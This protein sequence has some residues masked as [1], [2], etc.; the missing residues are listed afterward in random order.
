[1][2]EVCYGT[3]RRP[4]KRELKKRNQNNKSKCKSHGSRRQTSTVRAAHTKSSC[5]QI[6]HT[7]VA[8]GSTNKRSAATSPELS[9][10]GESTACHQSSRNRKVKRTMQNQH[11]SSNSFERASSCQSSSADH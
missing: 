8:Q 10:S 7:S 6:D 5:G 1:V 11:G 4:K 9:S 3:S 2:D